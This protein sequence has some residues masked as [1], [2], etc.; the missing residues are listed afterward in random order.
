MFLEQTNDYAAPN[1]L[2]EDIAPN[3]DA[4]RMLEGNIL[5]IKQ[6]HNNPL[7]IINMQDKDVYLTNFLV[8]RQ[9]L[10]TYRTKHHLQ[11]F[12]SFMET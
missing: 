7:N 3:V 8:R 5:V 10:V 1:T 2:L 4:D 9:V 6:H 12:H 11:N